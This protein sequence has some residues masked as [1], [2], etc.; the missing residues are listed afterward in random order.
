[1][2]DDDIYRFIKKGENICGVIAD[3]KTKKPIKNAEVK[4]SDAEGNTYKTFSSEAGTYCLNVPVDKQLTLE[5]SAE[6]YGDYTSILDVRTGDSEAP[7]INLV[8]K[9]RID[10]IVD[11]TQKDGGKLEGASVFLINEQTGE[12]VEQRSPENGIVKFDLFPNQ[13][14]KLK[15]G[16]VTEGGGVYDRFEKAISTMG[17]TKAEAINEK[18]ELTRFNQDYIYNLPNIYFDLNSSSLKAD[19]QKELDKIVVIMNIFPRMEV[20]MSAHTDSRG[21]AELN[22]KLSVL[23]AKACVD[24]LSKKGIDA[25]RLLAQGY[26][27]TQLKNKCKDGVTCTEAEHAINRRSEFK[28]LKLD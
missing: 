24:Y 20:E 18:A 1:M 6:G 5:A 22:M 21:S 9:G 28:V 27:E 15:V 12:I 4:L 17:F 10:L 7:A 3:A 13:Q 23:R 19:A 26:G 11:V 8:P 14:Y 16:K 25:K 2:G